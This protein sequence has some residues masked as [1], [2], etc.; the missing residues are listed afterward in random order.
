MKR[1]LISFRGFT[2]KLTQSM[3]HDT[4][5]IETKLPIE[6]IELIVQY[7]FE[8]ADTTDNGGCDASL[9]SVFFVD[10]AWRLAAFRVMT[11]RLRRPVIFKR[12]TMALAAVDTNYAITAT[13]IRHGE[14]VFW[15]AMLK[16]PDAVRSDT[17]RMAGAMAYVRNV[18]LSHLRLNATV[19]AAVNNGIVTGLV[20]G[21]N[22]A[23]VALTAPTHT[24]ALLDKIK[25]P[26]RLLM[27]M[28]LRLLHEQ[29]H[30]L[31]NHEK[32][33]RTIVA[34]LRSG[35]S[36]HGVENGDIPLLAD[37]EQA[38]SGIVHSD[39]VMPFYV[40]ALRR[41]VEKDFV[42]MFTS[43]H[44]AMKERYSSTVIVLMQHVYAHSNPR[45]PTSDG[46]AMSSYVWNYATAIVLDSIHANKDKDDIG[47]EVMF[48]DRIAK[49]IPDEYA[50]VCHRDKSAWDATKSLADGYVTTKKRKRR[51]TVED[52]PD[53][54]G[55]PL[56]IVRYA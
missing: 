30:Q 49:T 33:S 39:T 4:R 56:K 12:I 40:A 2:S 46:V 54:V 23:Y 10:R 5:A 53:F 45:I 35:L 38:L 24:H 16:S 29:V 37:T 20:T 18:V 9:S 26:R 44:G 48:A 3:F 36:K 19:I 50:K 43:K 51:D 6:I 27:R 42:T 41:T 14:A 11:F 1:T 31:G 21:E 22:L 47:I 55:P 15:N 52:H 8:A 25:V 32:V 28:L 7:V 17:T 13:V 34:V